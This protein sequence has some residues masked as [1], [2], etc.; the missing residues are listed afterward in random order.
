MLSSRISDSLLNDVTHLRNSWGW[1]MALGIL[2]ILT[3]A[4]CIVADV[5]ATFATMIIFGWFL[6]FSGIIALVHALRVHTWSGFL[7]SFLS[8]LLRGFTG[9]FLIRYPAVGAF[10]LTLIIASFFLVGGLFRT[11]GAATMRFPQWG[12]S[13]FS[14]IVSVA[15][16]IILL[17]ELPTSSLW[18]IGFA[19]G[20]DMIFEGASLVGVAAALRRLPQV[21][22][23]YKAA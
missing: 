3:G 16:G 2:L 6:L 17:A 15:L 9:F 20:I 13:L 8:A 22:A 19:I 4:L 7:L 18:F 1:I 12:W 10:A 21:V 14:G 5:T 23:T 11:I